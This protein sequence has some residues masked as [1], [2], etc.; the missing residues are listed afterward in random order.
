MISNIR[1]GFS[2]LLSLYDDT[3]T[4]AAEMLVRSLKLARGRVSPWSQTSI[5]PGQ[6]DIRVFWSSFKTQ[7]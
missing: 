7:A 2:V 4:L 6:E 1:P 5:I 3:I